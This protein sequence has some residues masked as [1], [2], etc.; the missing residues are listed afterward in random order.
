MPCV[1]SQLKAPPNARRYQ[2]S[3][4]AHDATERVTGGAH[5]VGDAAADAAGDVRTPRPRAVP[6]ERVRS[7]ASAPRIQHGKGS[8]RDRALRGPF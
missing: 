2:A 8:G 1:T 6:R 5:T 4:L 7:L 3:E